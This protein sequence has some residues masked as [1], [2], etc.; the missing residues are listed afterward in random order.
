[1]N[2][3]AV[4]INH[5]TSS[6]A[7]REKFHLTSTERELLLSELKNDPSVVEAF[8]LSTCNRTEIYANLLDRNP[9]TLLSILFSVKK[10]EF[11][12]SHRRYFYFY[13]GREAVRHLL[14]VSAG[15]DSLILGEKQILGQL[16][17]AAELSRS[18]G[19]LGKQF[20]ILSNIAVRTGKKARH[21]TQIDYGGS[22]IS[23][24][25]VAMAQK[26]L[27]NLE[28]KSVLIVGT[29]KMGELATNHLKQKG[30]EQLYVMNR[31]HE[32]AVE[33]T[34]RLGGTPVSFWEIK[35]M[36][37][38][39][40]VC[41]CSAGSPHYIITKDLIEKAMQTKPG[42][43]MICIDISVPRNIEP[44]VQSVNGVTLVTID[45][46]DKVV[47]ENGNKRRSAV[48]Q[49]EEIIGNKVDEFYRKLGKTGP[50]ESACIY[51]DKN[52]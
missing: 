44:T 3:L 5:K 12:V 6:L 23:W 17:D 29:G 27:G 4:G 34:K 20:N 25:A 11:T 32:K 49:V 45:D 14:S 22:S 15:L 28:D 31:T 52:I 7:I 9:D 43:K 51:T 26:L 2:I 10:V 19:M 24:A 1:M 40:D 16:K 33:L 37:E 39:V 36:L 50:V 18:K 8:V 46:L 30:A 41:I 47:E 13:E 21:E 48:C 38:C 35:N 42:R